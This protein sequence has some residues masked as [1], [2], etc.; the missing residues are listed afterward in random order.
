M[1]T[2][3]ATPSCENLRDACCFDCG[4]L[5]VVFGIVDLALCLVVNVGV[6]VALRIVVIEIVLGV[7]LLVVV[8]QTHQTRCLFVPVACG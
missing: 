7:N 5:V 8:K 2:D 6:D 3:V 4:T 1:R